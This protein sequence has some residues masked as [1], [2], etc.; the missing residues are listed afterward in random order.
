M[1]DRINEIKSNPK[2]ART[3]QLFNKYMESNLTKEELSE[4]MNLLVGLNFVFNPGVQK[5]PLPNVQIMASSIDHDN[6]RSEIA[7]YEHVDNLIEVSPDY[8]NAILKE[9]NPNRKMQLMFHL[10]DT[11]EH[12]TTH[13]RQANYAKY[14]DSLSSEDQLKIDTKIRDMAIGWKQRCQNMSVNDIKKSIKHVAPYIK[15]DITIPKGY[16]SSDE[17]FADVS[18]GMYAVKQHEVQARIHGAKMG[19]VIVSMI[20]LGGFTS[21]ENEQLIKKY[22]GFFNKNIADESN[23]DLIGMY[24][25]FESHFDAT[26]D[27][28]LSLV[29]SYEGINPKQTDKKF[30]MNS[31]LYPKVMAMFLKN[32]TLEQKMDLLKYSIYNGYKT[33]GNE[34]LKSISADPKYFEN[35]KEIDSELTTILTSSKIFDDGNNRD[36]RE[37]GLKTN[38]YQMDY[39]SLLSTEQYLN[40][41]GE[42]LEKEKPLYALNLLRNKLVND[43]YKVD[44][45]DYD[46]YKKISKSLIVAMERSLDYNKA[47]PGCESFLCEDYLECCNILL[48]INKNDPELEKMK[49]RY[50]NEITIDETKQSAKE[51]QLKIYGDR[52]I[53]HEQAII[54]NR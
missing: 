44:E 14:Y 31:I 2:M 50:I 51:K 49:Q 12:E 38:S 8:A 43:L 17:Y 16:T 45:N 36:Y 4:F 24:K 41:V 21:K 39:T 6:N 47:N 18:Y 40:V 26:N 13:Y 5:I 25:E 9:Q 20:A 53:K 52:Q 30:K 19:K 48:S 37:Y 15:D 10:I 7:H 29:E 42:L 11:I 32:K 33:F 23:T 28:L 27:E 35:K 34:V 22:I 46:K 1:A 54:N 3:A